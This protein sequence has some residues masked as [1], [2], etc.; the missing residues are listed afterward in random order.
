MKE[1]IQFDIFTYERY[2][3]DLSTDSYMQ[4]LE[5]TST[6]GGFDFD[7]NKLGEML[8]YQGLQVHPDQLESIA[9]Q[10]LMQHVYCTVTGEGDDAK[11]WV[12]IMRLF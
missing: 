3:T 8:N 10:L 9:T 11:Q 2:Y 1:F 4:R 6:S 12:I 7:T 5:N